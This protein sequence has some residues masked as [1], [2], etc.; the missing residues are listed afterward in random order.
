MLHRLGFLIAEIL[1]AGRL[2]L[3]ID[4]LVDHL[5]GIIIILKIDTPGLSLYLSIAAVGSNQFT[6]R[7]QGDFVIAVSFL[8]GKMSQQGLFYIRF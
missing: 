1:L 7:F 4:V 2:R 5:A 6:H 3:I 8:R